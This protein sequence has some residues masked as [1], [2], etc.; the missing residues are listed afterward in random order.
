MVP[1]E[2]IPTPDRSPAWRPAWSRE[3][4]AAS[5]I[6]AITSSAVERGVGTRACPMMPSGPSTTAWIF[7][8]PRS[9][10]QVASP[11][12]ACYPGRPA[13]HHGERP[14]LL[15]PALS[16]PAMASPRPSSSRS[17]ASWPTDASATVAGAAFATLGTNLAAFLAHE[18]G[19]WRGEEARLVWSETPIQEMGG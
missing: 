19:A 16:F 2:P 7:V 13:G 15:H 10:P 12:G 17:S 18:A 11:T 5:T 14:G 9:T 1:G 8:P 4:F 6:A 3:A